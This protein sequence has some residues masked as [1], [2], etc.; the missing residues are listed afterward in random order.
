MTAALLEIASLTKRFGGLVAVD[1][2][3][4]EVKEGSIHAV[5]GPNGAGKTTLFNLISG[6]EAPTQG[7]IRFQGRIIDAMPAHQRV[8]F[9]VRRTF[10]NIRLFEE[11]SVHENVLVGQHAIASSG[12][13]SLFAYRNRA[14]RRQREEAFA[15]LHRLNIGEYA[16]RQAGSLPYGP[17]RLVEIARAMASKPKLL[18]LDEPT[19]GMNATETAE[20]SRQIRA[21]RDGGVTVLLIEHHMEVVADLSDTITV[22]NFGSKIAEG[23]SEEILK[24]PAV[25]EAYLGSEYA[26]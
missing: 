6:A 5:I 2:L 3:D 15:I 4:L 19:S 8:R 18:L 9:G 14:D 20:V 22:L 23:T 13:T 24:E 26:A 10:Q 12:L 17:K 1:G 21:I 25:I 11:L 16:E 7:S